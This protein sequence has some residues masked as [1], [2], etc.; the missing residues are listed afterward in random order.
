[1]NSPD[2]APQ[3]PLNNV[4]LESAILGLKMALTDEEADELRQTFLD[5]FCKAILA[6]PTVKPVHT[7]PNGQIAPNAD[8]TFVVAETPE[9]ETG[10][11]AF[12]ALAGLKAAM[13]QVT[14][15]V[16]LPGAQLASMLAKSPHRIFVSGPDMHAEVERAEMQAIA[17]LSQQAAEAQQAAV[18]F[19]AALEAALTAVQ[20]EASEP[21]QE[22]VADAFT[23][24]YVHVPVAGP[25]DHNAKFVMMRAPHPQQPDKFQEIPLLT[26]DDRLLVFTGK[27]AMNRWHSGARN[28]VSL[29]GPIVV[30]LV[31]KTGVPGIA[32]NVGSGNKAMLRVENKRLRVE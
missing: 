16:F 3:E 6:V 22:A 21:N 7:L 17:K 30:D 1:M 5:T 20:A 18:Q 26:Q 27:E 28:A 11:P 8:V 4:D 15:A 12:T 32:M 9:K 24:G 25:S 19:N 23:G 29:P 14:N 31:G 10:I 13:P 2:T